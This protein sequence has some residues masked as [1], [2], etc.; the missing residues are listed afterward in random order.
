MEGVVPF[1]PRGSGMTGSRRCVHGPVHLPDA[2]VFL[3]EWAV[4]VL[5]LLAVEVGGLLLLDLLR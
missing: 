2:L 4:A 3:L 1:V 5:L